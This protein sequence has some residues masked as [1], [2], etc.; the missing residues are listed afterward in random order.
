MS[1][2]IQRPIQG[3]HNAAGLLVGVLGGDGREY[4]VTVSKFAS[5]A[6]RKKLPLVGL[7]D[8]VTGLLVGVRDAFGNESGVTATAQAVGGGRLATL[9]GMHDNTNALVGVYG[10]GDGTEY[11]ASFSGSVGASPLRFASPYN[12]LMTSVGVQPTTTLINGRGRMPFYIGSGDM[13]QLVLSFIGWYMGGGG[14]GGAIPLNNAYNIVKIAVEKDGA[15]GSVPVTFGGLRT[16]TINPLDNDVQSDPILPSSF[17]LPKFTRGDKYWIRFEYSV[18]S[19]TQFMPTGPLNYVSVGFPAAVSVFIDP[20]ANDMSPVDSFGQM[21]FTTG[22][23]NN[24]QVPMLPF[25]LGRAVSGDL[26]SIL[27]VGT[28]IVA[29]FGTGASQAYF[30]SDLVSNPLAGANFGLG[31][32]SGTIWNLTNPAIL[33]AWFKYAKYVMD[34]YGTN[35]FLNPPGSLTGAQTD[36][37]YIWNTAKANGVSAIL[38]PKLIPRTTAAPFDGTTPLNSA[39]ASGGNARLFND[40][41]DTQTANVTLMTRNSLRAGSTQSTDA[42]YQWTGG[43]TNTADGTHPNTAGYLLD[44]VDFRAGFALLP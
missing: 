25:V 3:L 24:Y 7:H 12:Y 35:Q 5:A 18:A 27:T 22:W 8:P 20:A 10:G 41:L 21:N 13:S 42:F 14:G 30:N 19:N 1:G 39:W 26:R 29:G 11:S 17:S 40:W 15:S 6:G 2:W 34:E 44:A 33:A 37:Q 32:S 16:K 28:S 23:N 4:A 36:S 38:R 31:G 43:V 9:M